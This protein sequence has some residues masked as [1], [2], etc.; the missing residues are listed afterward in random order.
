MTDP[1]A[2]LEL[3]RQ[4]NPVPD[5]E[6]TAL[7]RG[8]YESLLAEINRRSQ[9]MADQRTR[10]TT[11]KK[12][13]PRRRRRAAW[14]FGAAFALVVA[15]IGVTA[16]LLSGGEETAIQV[17]TTV[18]PTSPTTT[19]AREEAAA[20]VDT[21][22]TSE[23][24]GETESEIIEVTF[25]GNECT[26][27]GPTEVPPGDHAFV[28]TDVSDLGA[29]LFARRLVD[30][31]T[32]QHVLN[33]QEKAGGP[34]SYWPRPPWVRNA[35]LDDDPPE[36]DL[37]ENQQLLATTLRPANYSV[38]LYTTTGPELIWL[39]APLDVVKP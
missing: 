7:Q 12:S 27:S 18:T 30:P 10:E 34:G 1:T 15:V 33:A 16:V 31:Y 28:L 2:T 8:N 6:T 5:P 4:T 38:A 29:V 11:E 32:Y 13:G 35:V 19:S 24:T 14:A 22:A 20:P 23:P 36:I 26:F 9:P 37:A 17:T 39:C 21:A 3:V 25:D